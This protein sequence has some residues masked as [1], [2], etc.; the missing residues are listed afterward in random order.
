MYRLPRGS[1][2]SDD[3]E[4]NEIGRWY[5]APIFRNRMEKYMTKWML[6]Q[7]YEVDEVDHDE[8]IY[9]NYALKKDYI[10]LSKNM[11]KSKGWG[12]D[13]AFNGRDLLNKGENNEQ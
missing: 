13:I 2:M 1:I 10:H 3:H 8:H 7:V 6:T 11:F 12:V 4:V 9:F 5:D